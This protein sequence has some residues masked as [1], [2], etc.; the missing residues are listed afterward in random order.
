M[1]K[2]RSFVFK[3]IQIRLCSRR[4]CAHLTRMRTDVQIMC[5]LLGYLRCAESITFYP[6]TQNKPFSV[7]LRHKGVV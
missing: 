3:L 5:V 2:G 1:G 6:V 4:G 7:L